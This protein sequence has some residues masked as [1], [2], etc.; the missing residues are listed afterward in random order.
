MSTQSHLQFAIKESFSNYV[1][2]DVRK[3]AYVIPIYKRRDPLESVNY[4]PISM[5]PTL[6]KELKTFFPTNVRTS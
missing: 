3:K 2:P 1:F 4:R 6:A 5:T